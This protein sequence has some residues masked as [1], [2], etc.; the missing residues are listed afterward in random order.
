MTD[1]ENM[2]NAAVQPSEGEI[3]LGGIFKREY[4]AAIIE[5]KSGINKYCV[6][7]HGNS[8]SIPIM[9]ELQL[10]DYHVCSIIA[11]VD[12]SIMNIKLLRGGANIEAIKDIF[13]NS[14]V[15]DLKQFFRVEINQNLISTGE[16]YQIN[17]L[18]LE[19]VKVD[20]TLRRGV[21]LILVPRGKQGQYYEMM[22]KKHR[23][24]KPLNS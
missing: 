3:E 10:H 22:H 18:Q 24:S 1:D 7:L 16:L 14:R 21:E 17:R 9:R 23:E 11:D 8:L 15:Y 12:K 20:M 4:P 13:P 19:V 2:C 6:E 5:Y